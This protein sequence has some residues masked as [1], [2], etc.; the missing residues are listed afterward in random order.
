MGNIL[1]IINS[2]EHYH[3]VDNVNYIPCLTG[4]F[5]CSE[6]RNFTINELTLDEVKDEKC[7]YVI[8]IR[9]NDGLKKVF[10]LL[11]QKLID[12]VNNDKCSIVIDYEHEGNLDRKYLEKFQYN[13]Q[14]NKEKVKLKNIFILTGNLIKLEGY[15]VDV[16]PSMHFLN[17]MSFDAYD[18]KFR[19]NTDL[20]YV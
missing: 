14:K 20:G 8:E 6:L 16:I 4:P 19:R 9:C 13:I 7:I 10:D 11:P 15:G 12:L 3:N 18:S 5:L 2:D 1:N 17:N